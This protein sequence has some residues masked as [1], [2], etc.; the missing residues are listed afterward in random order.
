M[1]MD[2]WRAKLVASAA[3]LVICEAHKIFPE[4]RTWEA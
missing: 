4:P 2:Y 3:T 1:I